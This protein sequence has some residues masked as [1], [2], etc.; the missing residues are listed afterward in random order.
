MAM[1]RLSRVLAPIVGDRLRVEV[2]GSTLGEVVD[3]LLA[4]IPAVGVHLFDG[5]GV[6]RQ[7]VLCFVDGESTR[8]EDRA[9]P[10]REVEFL[11]AVSGG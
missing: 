4:E 10:A 2:E 1:V 8:L 7:H 3:A 11:H 6:L 5:E 9:I